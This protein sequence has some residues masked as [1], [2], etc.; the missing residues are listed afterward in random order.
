M[1]DLSVDLCE[2]VISGHFD[3]SVHYEQQM[4][5][6]KARQTGA[7]ELSTS[8]AQKAALPVRKLRAVSVFFPSGSY[9]M[10]KA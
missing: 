4:T 8:V 7:R 9:A 3:I 5:I 1:H 10:E 6:G 2:P